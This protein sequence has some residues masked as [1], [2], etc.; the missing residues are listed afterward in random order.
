MNYQWK[1]NGIIL[2]SGKGKDAKEEF[3]DGCTVKTK[4]SVSQ[5]PATDEDDSLFLPLNHGGVA[6]PPVPIMYHIPGSICPGSEFMEEVPVGKIGPHY[7]QSSNVFH[8]HKLKG[9]LMLTVGELDKNV[10]PASTIQVVDA[11]VRAGKDFEFIMIPG[12]G[13]GIGEGKYLFRKRIDFFVR[14]LLGVDPKR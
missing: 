10:D 12:A 7:E 2:K 13:H 4:K 8:A 3:I 14:S 9:D 11:L 5:E 1:E 6:V